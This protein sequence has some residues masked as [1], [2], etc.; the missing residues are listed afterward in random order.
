MTDTWI[1]DLTSYSWTQYTFGSNEARVC[2]TGLSGVGSNV[3]I[4]G[5]LNEIDDTFEAH[6]NVFHVMLEPKCLQQLAIQII[7]R[8]QDELPWNHLPMKL[9]YRLGWMDERFLGHLF[10]LPRLNWA[11][12]NLD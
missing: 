8:H 4:F 5:G 1:L 2:H 12:D 7:H 10:A 9:I 3:I 11:G 6:N